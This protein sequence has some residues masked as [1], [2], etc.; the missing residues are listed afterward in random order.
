MIDIISIVICI[1]TYSKLKSANEMQSKKLEIINSIGLILLIFFRISS[2]L[3]TILPHPIFILTTIILSVVYAFNIKK[4]RS[5]N[6]VL[7]TEV[8]C[9][10]CG[11]LVKGKIVF[12]PNCGEKIS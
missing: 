9:P 4:L 8:Y 5:L 12:C 3:L 1:L 7:E 2:I 6:A 11:R 10:K